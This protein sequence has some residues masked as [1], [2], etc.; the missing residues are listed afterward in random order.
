MFDALHCCLFADRCN[1]NQYIAL[2]RSFCFGGA[3][4]LQVRVVQGGAAPVSD[5]AETW[6]LDDDEVGRSRS[7]TFEGSVS[8]CTFEA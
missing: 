6:K 2:T 4:T 3:Q 5:T 7:C 1:R 8:M